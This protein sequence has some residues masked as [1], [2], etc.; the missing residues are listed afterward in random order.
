MFGKI[1]LSFE[2]FNTLRQNNNKK[3]II[4][5]KKF[6]S[7][8]IT[9]ISVC[10]KF[11]CYKQTIF[12][13]ESAIYD[14]NNGRFS[15]LALNPSKEW[16]FNL[17]DSDEKSVFNSLEKIILEEEFVKDE[18]LPKMYS[19]VGHVQED[20]LQSPSSFN[21]ENIDFGGHER[22]G[23]VGSHIREQHDFQH[24]HA[25]PFRAH[26]FHVS[27]PFHRRDGLTGLVS[28]AAND[29]RNMVL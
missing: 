17:S 15:I 26:H 2:E 6:S 20:L 7:D 27:D 9:P 25:S 8:Y 21:G 4:L 5:Y 24:R 28:G 16:Y 12:F 23:N 22:T 13:Y 29:H 19:R 11:H 14:K 3:N 18:T 10:Q 1:Q